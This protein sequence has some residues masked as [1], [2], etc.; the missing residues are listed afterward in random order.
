[1]PTLYFDR[2]GPFFWLARGN[3]TGTPRT[4]RAA[5]I[6]GLN[7]KQADALDA[8]HF[9]ASKHTVKVAPQ[10]GEMY[11]VNNFSVLHSRAA[12]TDDSTQ[13]QSHPR[14]RR[15]HLL[16][17]WLRDPN[18][19]RDIVE[20]TLKAR[21]KQVF[22][23][24]SAKTGRWLLFRDMAPDVISDALFKGNFPRDTFSSCSNN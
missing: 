8:V 16:R 23:L 19:G 2:K 24:E 4:P 17:M 22:D 15:R 14:G 3:Y 13:D 1:M 7:I 9:A 18:R 6:P 5:G 11:F 21:W 10:K 20:Q 12:F